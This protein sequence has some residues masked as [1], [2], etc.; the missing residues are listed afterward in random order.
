M[1]RVSEISARFG[2]KCLFQM[3]EMGEP[4]KQITPERPRLAINATI[5][6]DAPSL[7]VFNDPTED[8]RHPHGRHPTHYIVLQYS[9]VHGAAPPAALERVHCSETVQVASKCAKWKQMCGISR[10]C[11]S[12]LSV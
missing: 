11:D 6:S 3:G 7:H 5:F 2:A 8:C 4:P 10:S 9:D 12:W 1:P